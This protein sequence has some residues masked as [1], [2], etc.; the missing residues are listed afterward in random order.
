MGLF[1]RAMVIASAL[2]VAVAGATLTTPAKAGEGASSYS[3]EY[4]DALREAERFGRL[5]YEK[6]QA[7]WH[8]SDV[9]FADEGARSDR[10]LAGWI[11]EPVGKNEWR[12]LFYGRVGDDYAPL[13]SVNV[14]KG[15]A[16]KKLTRLPDGAQFN[17]L[18]AAMVRARSKA[19]SEPFVQCSNAYNTVIL[20]AD[21]GAF[22]VYLLAATTQAGVIMIGGHYRRLVDADGAAILETKSFTQGCMALPVPENAVGLVVTN[23][24]SPYA[25]ETYVFLNLQH[26]LPIYVITMEN[27]ITWRVENGEISVSED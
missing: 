2:L 25:G 17:D 7:A 10:R 15:K 9:L 18:Q 8:A 22:Y 1:Q 27:R 20:P 4:D 23:L 6:D 14:K 16:E 24:A 11:T 5:I 3:G 12:V 13:Y 26:K 21:D 19:L